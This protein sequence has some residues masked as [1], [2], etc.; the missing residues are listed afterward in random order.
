MSLDKEINDKIAVSIVLYK[1]ADAE[2]KSILDTLKASGVHKIITVDN[3]PTNSLQALVES[4]NVNYIFTGRNIGYGAAHNIAIRKSLSDPEVKYHLVLN[5]DIFFEPDVLYKIFR[6]MESR[7]D[8]GQL[9]PKI[10]YPN[11]EIQYSVRLLPSPFDLILRRFFP[12]N[13]F[14][15]SR[16]R[17]LLADRDLNIEANIP[18]HQGS[19]MFF[20][21]DAL[22]KV[23]LFDERFFMYPEDIDI[24]RRV[25]Q[26][27]KTIYWPDVTI[28]HDHR[29]QSYKSLKMFWIHSKNMILYFNKWGWIFDSERIRVN[30]K[31]LRELGLK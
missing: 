13:L 26:K 18:Y 21:L 9:I 22:R 20:R 2:V 8:V 27:F 31:I 12:E 16:R 28:I 1:T 3:S 5:S 4:F 14:K 23:G 6:F 24:T 11:G 15:M 29:A 25:F 7:E 17:Y 30:K 10:I 19:F